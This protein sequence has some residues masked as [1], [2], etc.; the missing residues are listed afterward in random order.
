[1]RRTILALASLSVATAAHA[2]AL[3]K[4]D[5]RQYCAQRPA[6]PGLPAD[7][8]RPMCVDAESE[9]YATLKENWKTYSAASLARC[10]QAASG[11]MQYSDLQACIVAAESK[12]ATQGW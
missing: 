12:Q 6:L 10:L 2:Q 4:L 5:I 8:F 7:L 1:M 3:P 9:S 11:K